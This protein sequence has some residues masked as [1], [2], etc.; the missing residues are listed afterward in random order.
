MSKSANPQKYANLTFFVFK[1]MSYGAI[2]A[3]FLTPDLCS[4]QTGVIAQ[5]VDFKIEIAAEIY[6][7][8]VMLSRTY[9]TAALSP[10]MSSWV[11]HETLPVESR[12]TLRPNTALSQ[13][14]TPTQWS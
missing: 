13:A 3:D 8:A 4:T 10:Q 9:A 11:T 1:N 6:R 12:H 7:N 5:Q 2:A 14:A